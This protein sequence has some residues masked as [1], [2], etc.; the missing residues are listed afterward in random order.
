MN[1][2]PYTKHEL[3]KALE[4][5]PGWFLDGGESLDLFLGRTTRTHH[6]IDVGIFSPNIEEFLAKLFNAGYRIYV[7]N[8]KLVSFSPAE[9]NLEDYNY[10]IADRQ[11]YRFQVLKYR[12][13]DGLVYFRR[14]NKIAWPIASFLIEKS[15]FSIINPLVTYAFKVTAS[16]VEDKDLADIAKLLEWVT[17][18]H[19]E[20]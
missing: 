6:D 19:Q 1:W 7:A 11:G 9:F 17:L 13:E 12:L 4:G 14:N 2:L 20:K 5:I 15:G 10:W 16:S 8:R 18:H 3:S